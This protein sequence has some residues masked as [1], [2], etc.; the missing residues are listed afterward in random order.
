MKKSLLKSLQDSPHYFFV[1]EQRELQ[2]LIE[3]KER[4]GFPSEV[5]I[6]WPFDN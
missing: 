6:A 3:A 2:T 5:I 1:F 4:D